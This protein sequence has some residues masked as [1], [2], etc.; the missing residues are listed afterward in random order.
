MPLIVPSGYSTFGDS[1]KT[2]GGPLAK[3]VYAQFRDDVDLD[4]VGRLRSS[5]GIEELGWDAVRMSRAK[6][7]T[8]KTLWMK[9][10][11]GVGKAT[12]IVSDPEPVYSTIQLAFSNRGMEEGVD[13]TEEDLFSGCA[14]ALVRGTP[15][16]YFPTEMMLSLQDPPM[17]ELA[18][19]ERFTPA[20]IQQK[21]GSGLRDARVFAARAVA[22][23][24]TPLTADHFGSMSDVWRSPLSRLVLR[25]VLAT[26]R[27]FDE[28][29]P[30][31]VELLNEA[32]IEIAGRL[33]T[34]WPLGDCDFDATEEVLEGNETRLHGEHRERTTAE[35][36]SLQSAGCS[37]ALTREASSRFFDQL[38]A[39]DVAA[40]WAREIIDTAGLNALGSK[41]HCV[42]INEK[43]IK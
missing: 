23:F 12:V 19:L 39:A 37:R 10:E 3:Y 2:E 38:Q 29:H 28:E 27:V 14:T 6:L 34:D 20:H 13:Y 21:I 43:R 11:S 16:A 33:N 24:D 30:K 25:E 40:G 32:A 17:L 26:E 22:L 41:F 36:H 7:K 35:P 42:W 5:L 1:T 8:D 4:W 9:V 31:S 15:I 18:T